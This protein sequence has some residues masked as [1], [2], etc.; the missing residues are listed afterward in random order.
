MRQACRAFEPLRGKLNE[1]KLEVYKEKNQAKYV[2]VFRQGQ[3]QFNACVASFIKK[4]CEWIEFDINNYK[5]TTE[6]VWADPTLK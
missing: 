6:Q 2:S 5:L 3:Q 1:A 4:A